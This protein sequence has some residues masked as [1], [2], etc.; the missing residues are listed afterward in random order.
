MHAQVAAALQVL[1]HVRRSRSGRVLESVSL[2]LP[3]GPERLVTV[4]PAWV[5]GRGPGVAAPALGMLLTERGIPV[6]PVLGEIRPGDRR[7]A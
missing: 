3:D 1:L 6:P 4:V 2:L 5:R 7:T